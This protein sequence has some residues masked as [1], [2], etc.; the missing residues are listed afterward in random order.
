M[1]ALRRLLIWFL[2]APG[3]ARFLANNGPRILSFGDRTF[4]FRWA[5]VCSVL[6]NDAF[7]LIA[8]INAERITALSGPFMLGMDRSPVLWTQRAAAYRALQAVDFGQSEAFLQAAAQERMAASLGVMDVVNDYARPLALQNAHRIFGIPGSG[9]NLFRDTLRAVFHETFL[10]LQNDPKVTQAGR[11]AG[12]RLTCWINDAIA[13]RKAQHG[14][15][16]TDMLGALLSEQ[17]VSRIDDAEIAAV[18]AGFLVGSVDTTT[19]AVAN[20]TFETLKDPLL[21]GAMSAAADANDIDLLRGWCW[22]ALRRRP[23]NQLLVRQAGPGAVVAGKVI[24]A[25]E[26]VICMLLAA[27]QDNAA[28]PDPARLDPA[29]PRDRYLHFGRALH[30]CAGRDLNAFQI[31]LLVGAIMSRGPELASPMTFSG[32]FPDRLLVRFKK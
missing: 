32:P 23:H 29:R 3:R 14:V 20:I 28:W 30:H 8:P 10:N 7:F 22:E 18:L 2:S 31:P 24:P 27:M 11:D 21:L 17:P 4:I 13:Q 5:D 9:G 25:G 16:S 12:N 26:T 1:R 19:T 6:E 15:A